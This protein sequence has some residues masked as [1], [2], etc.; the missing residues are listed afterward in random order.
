M[1]QNDDVVQITGYTNAET[2]DGDVYKKEIVEPLIRTRDC[3]YIVQGTVEITLNGELVSSLD[4][5][6]GECNDTAILTQNG[7][8]T[9]I[10]LSEIRCKSAK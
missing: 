5:G 4:Y 3:R 7:E 10:D 9:E 1:E 8:S 2:S 6:D